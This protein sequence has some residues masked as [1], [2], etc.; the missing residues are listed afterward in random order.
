MIGGLLAALF[1]G[2]G[3]AG[4]SIAWNKAKL[5]TDRAELLADQLKAESERRRTAEQQTEWYRSRFNHPSIR[6]VK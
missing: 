3:Y 2:I 6:S 5:A 4:W 1:A